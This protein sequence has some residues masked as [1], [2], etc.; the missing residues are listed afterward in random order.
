MVSRKH[1]RQEE[2]E[3]EQHSDTIPVLPTLVILEHICPFVEDR[4]SWNALV[5]MDQDLYVASKYQKSVIVP[6]WPNG[7]SVPL[8]THSTVHTVAFSHDGQLLA[9]GGRSGLIRVWDIRTGLHHPILD[10][11]GRD[12][13]LSVAFAPNG[14]FLASA[15][16]DTIRLWN[17]DMDRSVDDSVREGNGNTK[18]TPGRVFESDDDDEPMHVCSIAVSPQSQW[19]VS[20]NAGYPYLA[21]L[22]SVET[23]RVVRFLSLEGGS[24]TSVLSVAFSPDGTTIACGCFDRTVRL[25][26]LDVASTA[27]NQIQT[28]AWMA[29]GNKVKAVAFST[30]TTLASASLGFLHREDEATIRVW[31]INTNADTSVNAVDQTPPPACVLRVSPENPNINTHTIAFSPSG[32]ILCSGGMDGKVQLWNVQDGSCITVLPGHGLHPVYSV[33]FSPNGRTVASASRDE[34]IRLWTIPPS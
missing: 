5:M 15:S 16:H 2:Q 12:E 1:A 6:P 26:H 9:G 22:W 20:G 25:W 24:P 29:H 30:S 34:T 27:I 23:G 8:K 33:A 28:T 7:N 14:R 10:G 4:I 21:S 19:V 17:L 3:Q 32:K 31:N 11:H 13:V 18:L